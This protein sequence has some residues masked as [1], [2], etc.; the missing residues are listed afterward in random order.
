MAKNIRKLIYKFY[1]IRQFLTVNQFRIVY[2]ALVESIV[3]YGI[4]QLWVTAYGSAESI[5]YD[6]AIVITLLSVIRKSCVSAS[7]K[8]KIK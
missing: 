1:Q 8:E 2:Y 7:S 3:V 5:Y 4:L 6:I